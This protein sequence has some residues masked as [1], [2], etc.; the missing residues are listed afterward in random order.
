[1]K[2][3]QLF[4]AVAV[5][6]LGL[7]ALARADEITRTYN[8]ENWGAVSGNV[9]DDDFAL[10]DVMSIKSVSVTL[11]HSWMSDIDMVLTGPDGDV[12][13]LMTDQDGSNDLG[14]GG[15]FALANVFEYVFV[16]P[17]TTG[18]TIGDASF[19]DPRPAGTYDAES[20]GDGS[21]A[22]NWN[23]N[24]A[25]DSDNDMGSIGTVVIT[26]NPVPEPS[27]GLSGLVGMFVTRLLRRRG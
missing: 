23:F 13:D 8:L 9:I 14:D 24:L 5:L 6:L 4:L 1:M 26:Y 2:V 3:T 11:A 25:D 16:P 7:G 10:P 18:F 27:V 17:G 12:Y 19:P 22:G 15:G 21:P 20:W